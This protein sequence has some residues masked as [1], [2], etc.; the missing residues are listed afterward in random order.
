MMRVV[1]GSRRALCY[2]IVAAVWICGAVSWAQ[3]FPIK[4]VHYVI[5]FPAGSGNDIVG[6]LIT[7]R[8]THLWGQQVVVDNRV[9][10]SGT[11]GAAFV[12]KS[13]PDGYTLLH[14]NIAPN[15]ISLSM[16]AKIPY[17]HRDFAPITRIGMPPN[18]IVVHPSVPFKSINDLVMHAKAN[19]G[20]LNYAAGTVGTSPHLTMEW[21]KLR[22]KFDIVHIPYKND[23]QGT[24]DVIAGQLPI[25]ITNFPF[26]V[27]PVQAGRLRA[28]AVASAQ[29]Q[30]LL[31]DVPTMQESGVPDFEVNSWYGV[32]APAAT[33]VALLDKLNADIRSVMRIPEVG[34][35]L[36]DLGMPPAPTSREEFDKFMRAEI[37]RWAQVIKDA[38]IPKL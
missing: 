6:R 3:N 16:M 26:L 36:T 33:P 23:T 28:L 29:R 7:E 38:G 19:P 17:E 27:A 5:P 34:Q 30:T 8:L 21:L 22:M 9:G 32:C 31:P 11:I 24:T 18:V 12:A 13:P 10:A 37:A 2:A 1:I 35:R 15:A 25:N 4:P 20:K 14:C